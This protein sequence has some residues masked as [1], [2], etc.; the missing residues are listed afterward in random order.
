MLVVPS[1][2]TV[3]CHCLLLQENE[4]LALID[5]ASQFV[6][7]QVEASGPGC[8]WTIPGRCCYRLT[9]GKLLSFNVRFRAHKPLGC[10]ASCVCSCLSSFTPDVKLDTQLSELSPLSNRSQTTIACSL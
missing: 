10:V 8:D 3:V 4:Q 2:L 1:Y 9:Q 7:K 6:L 5:M